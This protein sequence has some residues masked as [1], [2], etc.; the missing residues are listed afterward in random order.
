MPNYPNPLNEQDYAN[1]NELCKHCHGTSQMI[2]DYKEC[3][4]PCE[5]HEFK[6]NAQQEL[7][8]NIKR[9]FFPLNT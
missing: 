7:A 5:E 4:I 2:A 9:K 3:G 8:Q 6:N 1:L